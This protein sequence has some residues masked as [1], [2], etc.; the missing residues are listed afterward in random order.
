MKIELKPNES[1]AVTFEETSG[2]IAVSFSETA[3]TVMADLPD[4][5]GREGVI[6][7]EIGD[8][9]SMSDRPGDVI[10]TREDQEIATREALELRGI[11]PEIAEVIKSLEGKPHNIVHVPGVFLSDEHAEALRAWALA[12]ITPG[13]TSGWGP[14]TP[15]AVESRR[16][17]PAIVNT[18]NKA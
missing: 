3:V 10:H 6:Y 15:D 9:R 11:T 18:G 8:L 5:L 7:Q 2:E 13:G 1:I 4:T 12:A 14:T 17:K 16:H